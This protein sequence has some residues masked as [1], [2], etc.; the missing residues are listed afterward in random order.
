M[1]PS[2]RH[3]I[4]ES[5]PMNNTQACPSN[6]KGTDRKTVASGR[7]ARLPL[8]SFFC[9]TDRYGRRYLSGRLGLMK[10]LIFET[11]QTSQG[12]AVWE[13]VLVEGP[14]PTDEQRALA[15]E[16]EHESQ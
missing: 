11:G 15:Q 16:L 8:G 10:L 13:G 6:G 5:D 1:C 2:D 14:H 12:D 9:R 4:E 3:R 7:P